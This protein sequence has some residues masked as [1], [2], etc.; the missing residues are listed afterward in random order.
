MNKLKDSLNN[1]KYHSILSNSNNKVIMYRLH[2]NQNQPLKLMWCKNQIQSRIQLL[3]T[4]TNTKIINQHKI[5]IKMNIIKLKKIKM[6][7]IKIK[8]IQK[9]TITYCKKTPILLLVN[10]KYLEIVWNKI[11]NRNL[12]SSYKKW[13]LKKVS[14]IRNSF[15][16]RTFIRTRIQ[17]SEY[18]NLFILTFV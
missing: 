15:W 4:K 3:F 14:S 1:L 2:H 18:N 12:M 17:P 8:L 5:P 6:K 13:I 9:V 16:N 10:S 7:T 11:S